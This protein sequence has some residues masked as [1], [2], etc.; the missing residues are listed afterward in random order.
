MSA[1]SQQVGWLRGM[2][3]NPKE[4]RLWA[5]D[6]PVAR[7]VTLAFGALIAVVS[8]MLVMTA[9]GLVGARSNVTELNSVVEQQRQLLSARIA[10]FEAQDRIKA[11]VIDGDAKTATQA[12]TKLA[13]ARTM[14]AK[15]V[16]LASDDD[17][18]EALKQALKLADSYVAEFEQ[19]AKMQSQIKELGN[20]QQFVLG[21]Q[22]RDMV[23]DVRDTAYA[24]GETNAAFK[25]AL[26]GEHYLISRLAVERYL[27][28]STP[29]TVKAATDAGLELEDSLN[30]LFEATESK[31]LTEKAD[32]IIAKLL[33]RD[34]AFKT[35]IKTT[36]SRDKLLKDMFSNKG[37]KIVASVGGVAD[38]VSGVQYDAA[39][40]ANAKLNMLLLL[41][42]VVIGLTLLLARI[43]NRSFDNVLTKP[44]GMITDAMRSLAAGK[45]DVSVGGAER[46]D[47]VGAMAQAVEVFRS[48]AVEMQRLQAEQEQRRREREEAEREQRER[49][50]REAIERQ[51]AR[52]QAETERKRMLVE[53]AESFEANVRHVVDAVAAAAVQIEQGA[54]TVAATAQ[55]NMSIT[56]SAAEAAQE[57]SSSTQMVA[58]AT[59]EMSRSLAEVSGQVVQSSRIAEQAVKRAELTDE[60]V[61]GLARDAQNIGEVIELIQN[62]AEQTN[63]LAL[64]A[65]IEAARAG[66]AGRGFAVVAS[67]VKNLATQ[68]ASATSQIAG[69]IAS[70]QSV[71]GT[72][73]EAIGDI[74]KTVREMGEISTAVAAAVE[75][76]AATTSD[77]AHNTTQAA[78]GSQQVAEN[79][80]QVRQGVTTTT[81]AADSALQAASELTSQAA[82]LRE[83]VDRFIE[84]VRAA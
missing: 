73:V 84:R 43:V 45:L 13:E 33:E 6:L 25:A 12:R 27:I 59:D 14:I 83:Q 17:Q 18:E 44:I 62:I 30:A 56:E 79:I 32:A 52:E 54:R 28:E 60:I 46:K 51:A 4:F 9:L 29:A 1:L 21:P 35:L 8:V 15:S 48:N 41:A 42:P 36:Q 61:A 57:A 65:T 38:Q 71:T 10:T 20:T 3:L 22:I 64:N 19:V 40:G 63:L 47:E 34:E 26:V 80:L 82:T 78:S 39:A 55:T 69:Q 31:N 67:E 72:A 5:S 70:I 7:K 81:E 37:P 66:A 68:T 77:I 49:E 53:F 23:T 50:Q 2:P 76:Q 24:A 58:A 11:F 74:R 16:E 75:E